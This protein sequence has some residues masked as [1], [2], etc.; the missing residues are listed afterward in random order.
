LTP[1]RER[2]RQRSIDSKSTDCAKRSLELLGK[3]SNKKLG[4]RSGEMLR[5]SRLAVDLQDIRRIGVSARVRLLRIPDKILRIRS[6][7]DVCPVLIVETHGPL[8]L[9]KGLSICTSR[10]HDS[11][12]IRHQTLKR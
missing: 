10:P 3:R 9:L 4:K 12:N 11:T 1:C 2:S 6:T 7:P 8:F 5:T